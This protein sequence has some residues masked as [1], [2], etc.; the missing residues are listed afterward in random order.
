MVC[1]P[2]HSDTNEFKHGLDR[3]PGASNISVLA[4]RFFFFSPLAGCREARG[5]VVQGR[6]S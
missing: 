4:L 3:R 5:L 2:S 6:Q 1:F